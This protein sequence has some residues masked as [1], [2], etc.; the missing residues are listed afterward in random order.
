M[1]FQVSAQASTLFAARLTQVIGTRGNNG[2]STENHVA[3]SAA[4]VP[5]RF[6]QPVVETQRCRDKVRLVLLRRF[7]FDAH[8]LLKCDDVSIYLSQDVRYARRAHAPVKAAALVDVIRYYSELFPSMH[9]F[10][11]PFSP[12][13]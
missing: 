13:T 8:D 6:T 10:T 3:V 1:E 2:Q 7:S 4:F 5:S 12:A 9:Y 11:A